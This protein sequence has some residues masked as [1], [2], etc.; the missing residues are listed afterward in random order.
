MKKDLIS[1][2]IPIFKNGS[3]KLAKKILKEETAF[4]QFLWDTLVCTSA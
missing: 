1:V 4:Q 2:I 3:F